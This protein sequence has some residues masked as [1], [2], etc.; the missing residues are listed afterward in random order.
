MK[1]TRRCLRLPQA[2]RSVFGQNGRAADH[3]VAVASLGT[4]LSPDEF[5]EEKS[6]PGHGFRDEFA[7][8]HTEIIR[9]HYQIPKSRSKSSAS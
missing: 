9:S 1:K 5:V 6:V 7:G 3:A 2:I 4:G 8:V